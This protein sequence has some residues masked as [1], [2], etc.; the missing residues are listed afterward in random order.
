[1]APETLDELK[2]DAQGACF[3]TLTQRATPNWCHLD[4]F[5]PICDIVGAPVAT[6]EEW[7]ASSAAKFKPG[8]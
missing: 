5:G 7:A 4:P 3:A 6:N 2:T 8:I 1:M